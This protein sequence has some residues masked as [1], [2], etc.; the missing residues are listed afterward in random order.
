[1]KLLKEGDPDSL[2]PLEQ[3]LHS[4]ALEPNLSL[5]K[6]GSEEECEMIVAEVISLRSQLLAGQMSS[7]SEEE[8][9]VGNTGRFLTYIP[10]ENMADGA[11]RYASKGF[12]D[13]YDTPPWDLWLHYSDRTLVS[14]VPSLL[15]PL[16]QDGIDANAFDC[17]NCANSLLLRTTALHSPES[18]APASWPS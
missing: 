13:P 10:S 17:I 11:S 15:V 8:P 14:W 9:N 12:F 4:P 18:P 6:A 3:E 5:A 1:M 7:P 16:A 2:A